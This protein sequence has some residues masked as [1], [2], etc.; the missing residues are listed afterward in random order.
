MRLVSVGRIAAC[1]VV[2][3]VF[4]LPLCAQQSNSQD[5]TTAKSGKVVRLTPLT[6]TATRTVKTVFEAPQPVAV[7][8]QHRIQESNANTVTDLFRTQAGLDVTGVGANQ[9]RPSIRGQRGQRILLLQDGMRLS[10]SRRQQDF[11]ELPALVNVNS[12][13]R[14]EVVRGPASVLYGSDAIGGVVNMI[15]R[16][17]EEEGI[18]GTVGYRYSSAIESASGC[19]AASS[20]LGCRDTQN[21]VVGRLLGRFGSLSFAAGGSFRDSD[22]H[23]APNG[24]FGDITLD[25]ET[26][27]LDTG[28]RDVSAD[29]YVGYAVAAGQRVFGKF[30]YYDADTAGFGWVD[31]DVFD[32]GSP[33]IEIRYPFQTF[34][35]YTLGY[36]GEALN[37]PVADRVGFVGYYQSNERELTNDIF[38]PFGSPDMG[39]RV[40]SANY[41]DI[42]TVG[43]RLEASKLALLDRVNFTYGAD[44]FQDET[45]NRDSSVTTYVGFPAAPPFLPDTSL[46]PN[47]PN[48]T[49]RSIGAFVQGDIQVTHWASLILGARYQN[50][51]AETQ[52][53]TGFTGDPTDQTNDAFVGAANAIFEV[54]DQLTLIGAVGRAFRSPNIVEQFFEG[55]TPE[56]S[57]FQSRNPDLKPE[58]SFN[59]DL[60]ARYRDSRLF[61]EG[62][63]FRNMITDG[64]RII[65]TGDSVGPF[66]EVINDNVDKLRFMG[67]ELSGDVR[68]PRGFS[69][70]AHFTYFDTEDVSEQGPDALDEAGNPVGDSYSSKIGGTLRYT[71][72]EGLFFVEYEVRRNGD[73]RDAFCALETVAQCDADESLAGLKPAIGWVL[74]AFTVH[75]ARA[76]V[77]LLRRGPFA[78]RIGIA[79]SNITDELYAEFSNASFFRP[80]AR[81][82]VTLTYDVSF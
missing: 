47:V 14:V 77:H 62:F 41:T 25:N 36:D 18:H 63:V 38:I 7:I 49:Y 72:P 59:V 1:A 45:D 2:L 56:G 50:I 35:K 39:V 82:R 78:H 71:H 19:G 53:T 75:D 64:I 67:V 26:R 70:G 11:G 10:N 66:F 30:E 24:S 52:A 8:D 29:G 81:R 46:A 74:P 16:T 55:P 65:P 68:L 34:Q 22:G 5:T 37:T 13:Q 76:A 15:T 58:K 12:V 3:T 60:G 61:L 40:N 44:L 57:G 20:E 42:Q 4:S 48:A 28:L 32:A 73:R 54:T 69:A 21:G 33:T 79:V 6:V 27:V 51:H 31:P 43:L 23:H 17:P 80:E 9:A